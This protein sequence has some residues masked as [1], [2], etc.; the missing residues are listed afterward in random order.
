MQKSSSK[1]PDPHAAV[2]KY[3]G[4]YRLLMGPN[5][6]QTQELTDLN[7]KVVAGP[8]AY[9][10]FDYGGRPTVLARPSASAIA[11][12]LERAPDL[13][14]KRDDK[15]LT[16]FAGSAASSAVV[17]GGNSRSGQTA[18]KKKKYGYKDE[19]AAR[20]TVAALAAAEPTYQ[21][22]VLCALT[23]RAANHPHQTPGMRKSIGV[24]EA[25]TRRL[26]GSRPSSN[27]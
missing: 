6:Q 9:V 2:N 12:Q 18:N 7:V 10:F 15:R 22:Q 13:E 21:R 24:F 17:R 23:N 14:Y 8:T 19:A 27:K 1:A 3:T 20:S 5:L 11:A 16:L 26:S 25:R 4:S